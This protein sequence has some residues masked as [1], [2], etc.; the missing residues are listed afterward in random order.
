MNR[1]LLVI[2]D[3]EG[4]RS[5]LSNAL[6]DEGFEVEQAESGN[7]A[8]DKFKTRAFPVVITDLRM[9]DGTGLEVLEGVK[10]QHDTAQVIILTGES[11]METAMKAVKLHA[12]DYVTK[13]GGRMLTVI[14][15][16]VNRAFAQYE[17][18]IGRAE[19]QELVRTLRLV[20]GDS[21][22][23]VKPQAVRSMW[24]QRLKENS[25]SIQAMKQLGLLEYNLG[26]F[27]EAEYFFQ[28]AVDQD[29][30]DAE[31]LYYM[32]NIRVQMERYDQAVT[33]LKSVLAIDPNY[34]E[35]HFSL[36]VVHGHL[37]EID[38]A[39]KC[40]HKALGQKPSFQ[41]T[42]RCIGVAYGEIAGY[43]KALAD[44]QQ[45][46]DKKNHKMRDFLCNLS[47][48]LIHRHRNEPEAAIAKLKAALTIRDT[49]PFVLLILGMTYRDWGDHQNYRK[50]FI[51][52]FKAD[53][54]FAFSIYEIE[55]EK[56]QKL[57]KAQAQLET[58][59]SMMSYLS[60]TMRNTMAGG[61][62][63]V[64]QSIRSVQE[65]LG[66]RFNENPAYLAFNN[67]S[68]LVN[69]FSSMSSMLDTFKL[70][71]TDPERFATYWAV[72]SGND[73][74][75]HALYDHVLKQVCTRLL[76]EESLLGQVKKLAGFH[77]ANL[78]N[79]RKSFIATILASDKD[80][81]PTTSTISWMEAHFPI[82]KMT[83][84]GDPIRF[85]R[86]G[87]R[88]NFLFS[89]ISE[90]VYNAFKYTDGDKPVSLEW[91]ADTE[92]HHL[93]CINSFDTTSAKPAGTGKG[94]EFIENLSRLNDGMRFDVT[95]E[96][97]RFETK[98]TI[99]TLL[100]N[101]GKV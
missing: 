58:R 90:M 67:I 11:S 83:I 21:I 92:A 73:L 101:G 53:P 71:V 24:S 59:D 50:N 70:L 25:E 95:R 86:A 36:G 77:G 31:A 22:V 33:L 44:Y 1:R 61:P 82:I 54:D 79:L 75:Q 27:T 96:A 64:D 42:L 87:I 9:G 4:L 38:E 97:P 16:T 7:R 43:D 10:D 19:K 34:S 17:K 47:M 80:T 94:L 99:K 3:D 88:F 49:D 57:Q 15:D 41:R 48:A 98:L 91:L 20:D 45:T 85:S 76:F 6:A 68:G 72:D 8:L 63:L 12:F 46:R 14:L 52:A 81:N 18:E 28:M 23:I 13:S 84:D 100:F 93:R 62:G 66:D 30:K 74:T 51:D 29:P 69:I 55:S 5:V 39:L 89:C 60:H 32:G 78:R 56:A 26:N 35:A 2:D 65:L 37:G 40:F